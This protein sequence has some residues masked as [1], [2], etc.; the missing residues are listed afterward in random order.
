MVAAFKKGA[1]IT[2][3]TSI[4]LII[5]SIVVFLVVRYQERHKHAR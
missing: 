1:R 2:M 3:W 5:F 4:S